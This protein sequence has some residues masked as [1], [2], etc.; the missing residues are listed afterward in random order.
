MCMNW[1]TSPELKCKIPGYAKCLHASLECDF[2]QKHLL[3]KN[4]SIQWNN[5]PTSITMGN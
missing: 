5:I 3:N 2:V 4:C 1:R